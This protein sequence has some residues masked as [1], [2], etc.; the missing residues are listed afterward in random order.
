MKMNK[1]KCIN[2]VEYLFSSHF[3]KILNFV[4]VWKRFWLFW[5]LFSN[6]IRLIV[7]QANKNH[8]KNIGFLTSIWNS[9]EKFFC[10]FSFQFPF[11]IHHLF[12][13]KL[14]DRQFLG[15][16]NIRLS[17]VCEKKKSNLF[18]FQRLIAIDC[19]KLCCA[20][21]EHHYSFHCKKKVLKCDG[22]AGTH[23]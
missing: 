17:N 15:Y 19:K 22:I 9:L 7:C 16:R 2:R 4:F 11:G 5:V 3:N 12:I 21:F 10:V 6:M 13:F 8:C 1:W 20:F 14:N 18:I 23:L